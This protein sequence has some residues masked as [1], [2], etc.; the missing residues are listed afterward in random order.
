MP[1]SALDLLKNIRTL[2]DITPKGDIPMSPEALRNW[3]AKRPFE[4]F[5]VTASSG[6]TYDVR[7]PEMA[8]VT[9]R[10]LLVG[11]GERDGIPARY[12]TLALL[13]VTA[14]EPLDP[15]TTA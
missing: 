12:K 7:H 3:L 4:P 9:M 8:M 5:R 11:V 2:R 1:H 13:H 14:V 6:E 15:A 10:E